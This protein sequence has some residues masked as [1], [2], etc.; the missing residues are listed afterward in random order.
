MP[1]VSSHPSALPMVQRLR[2]L[3]PVGLM[4]QFI[5]RGPVEWT[6]LISLTLLSAWLMH[7][8][9]PIAMSYDIP[10]ILWYDVMPV[11]HKVYDWESIR[12]PVRSLIVYPQTLIFKAFSDYGITMHYFSCLVYSYAIMLLYRTIRAIS[13]SDTVYSL[14][15]VLLFLSFGHSE[16]LLFTPDSYPY[17]MMFL[18]LAFKCIWVDRQ[19][20]PVSDNILMALVAGMTVT[21]GI[22]LALLFLFAE[23]NISRG[24]IRTLRSLI[25][26]VLISLPCI[27]ID[28]IPRASLLGGVNFTNIITAIFAETPYHFHTFDPSVTPRLIWE[29]F[30]SDPLALHTYDMSVFDRRPMSPPYSW[31]L[32]LAIMAVT[33]YSAWH[34]RHNATTWLILA[35]M[36]ADIAIASKF[37][38]I[39]SQIFCAHW[40]FL[41]PIMFSLNQWKSVSARRI[42]AGIILLLTTALLCHNIPMIWNFFISQS[43]QIA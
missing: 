17:S 2:R 25:L 41:L 24:I 34:N 10:S 22:K 7:K 27:W 8:A 37:A 13:M 11:P 36:A 42:F 9:M 32:P 3:C 19:D 20:N 14:L 31:Q 30:W 21:N 16:L 23:K 12:H 15:L 18:L 1:N 35:W 29:H 6:L 4:R 5:P 28:I 43:A 26:L 38:T 33:I 40:F 39:E